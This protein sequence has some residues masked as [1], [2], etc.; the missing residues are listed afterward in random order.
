VANPQHFTLVANVVKTFTLDL[1]YN[2]VEVV[3]LDG[4]G[5]VYFTVD[6]STPVVGQD[7]C[8]VLPA[9]ICSMEVPV[10]TSGPTVVKAKAAG[11]VRISVR[12]I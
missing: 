2:R 9:A 5:E 11:A 4:A 6:T 10:P 7:G 12:G 8:Q 3:N 1:D